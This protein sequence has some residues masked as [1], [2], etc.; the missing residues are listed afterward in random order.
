MEKRNR[1]GKMVR[2]AR[3]AATVMELKMMVRPDV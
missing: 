2:D 1:C 3:A